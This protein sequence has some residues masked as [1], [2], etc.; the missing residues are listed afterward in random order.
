MDEPVDQGPV[1]VLEADAMTLVIPPGGFLDHAY[2]TCPAVR[3]ARCRYPNL[4][5][6][7]DPGQEWA[8]GELELER[9]ETRPFGL[10]GW[11]WRVYQARRL[12]A[13]K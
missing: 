1:D 10:C 3:V 13:Q 7:V 11:C 6:L 12:R 5:V 8:L 2:E 9:G 4:P